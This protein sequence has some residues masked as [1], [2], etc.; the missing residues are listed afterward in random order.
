M[1]AGTTKPTTSPAIYLASSEEILSLDTPKLKD[2]TAID[3]DVL[4]KTSAFINNESRSEPFNEF[5]AMS[6]RRGRIRT[7]ENGTS[8]DLSRDSSRDE[9]TSKGDER[10]SKKGFFG[11]LKNFVSKSQD[12]SD[13]ESEKSQKK[14]KRAKKKKK[15]PTLERPPL[16]E[17]PSH[18][19]RK[20]KL[21]TPTDD[22]PELVY[23][24]YV[25]SSSIE[26]E[27]QSTNFEATT[28][29]VP[30]ETATS[31]SHL[32]QNST[33]SERN[34]R[35]V[36]ASEEV[37]DSLEPIIY[38]R[39]EFTVVVTPKAETVNEPLVTVGDLPPLRP[40]RRKEHVYEDIDQKPD[41]DIKLLT[42]N[43]IYNETHFNP[44][45]D[46]KHIPAVDSTFP[47][48]KKSTPDAQKQRKKHGKL[49]GF[50]TKKSS[51]EVDDSE[52]EVDTDRDI[53]EKQ[54]RESSK[55]RQIKGSFSDEENS[56]QKKTGFF[57]IFVKKS[58]KE[59]EHKE[60]YT[61]TEKKKEKVDVTFK[62]YID[63]TKEPRKNV[64]S[65]EVL[66][67]IKDSDNFLKE[68]ISRFEDVRE[69]TEKQ[70]RESSKERQLKRNFSHEET[71]E[72]KKTGF[73]GIFVKK[74]KKEDD[75][76]E[77]NLATEKKKQKVGAAFKTYIDYTKDSGTKV[78]S[79]EVLEHM[80][81]SDNF[82]KEEISQFEDVRENIEKQ[83]LESSKERQTKGRFSDEE[84]SEQKKSGF[85]GMFMKK[86]KK[87]DD[88]MTEK[89]QKVNT[90]F[91]AYINYDNEEPR[92]MV[93]SNAV[94]KHMKD[95]DNF[96]KEEIAHF[97]DLK[98]RVDPQQ[99]KS[100]KDELQ[101]SKDVKIKEQQPEVV[102]IQQET[103]VEKG[104]YKQK[105]RKDKK[106]LNESEEESD[107]RR[108]GFF[109]LFG[110]KHKKDDAVYVE[111]IPVAEKTVLNV[112][113]VVPNG[114]N[115]SNTFLE[116]EIKYF[117]DVKLV[118]PP[119]QELKIDTHEAIKESDKNSQQI[120]DH[121]VNNLNDIHQINDQPTITL[122]ITIKK[123]QSEILIEKPKDII[124]ESVEDVQNK[125]KGKLNAEKTHDFLNQEILAHEDVK[126]IPVKENIISRTIEAKKSKR[127]DN[128]KNGSIL[129]DEN[130]G[131][132]KSGFFGIFRKK[133]KK[134]GKAIKERS[135][136][137]GKDLQLL[138]QPELNKEIYVSRI[139]INDTD[140]FLKTEIEKFHDVKEFIS[141]H[142]KFTGTPTRDTYE[143]ESVYV[144]K[145]YTK[146]QS[147]DLLKNKAR[148]Y[149]EVIDEMKLINDTNQF[150]S[151]EV[152]HFDDV[153]LVKNQEI[154]IKTLLEE[155]FGE[156]E[157]E[158]IIKLEKSI[159]NEKQ[160][161]EDIL[162]ILSNTNRFLRD[163]ILHFE[164]AKILKSKFEPIAEISKLKDSH[165]RL[166]K[167]NAKKS[168]ELQLDIAIVNE[169]LNTEIK[170][171]EDVKSI[172]IAQP[173]S[174]KSDIRLKV[175]HVPKIEEQK[176]KQDKND[177]GGGVFDIVGKKKHRSSKETKKSSTETEALS[178]QNL[179]KITQPTDQ[180][181]YDEILHFN[182]VILFKDKIVPIISNIKYENIHLENVE[183]KINKH[184]T[185]ESE[186][187]LFNITEIDDFLNTEIK[188]FEDVMVIDIFKPDDVHEVTH[189]S[190][191]FLSDE[192]LNIDVMKSS[193]CKGKPKVK[194][195]ELHIK[196]HH[197][198]DSK[199]GARELQKAMTDTTSTNDFLSTKIKKFE[200]VTKIEIEES[201]IKNQEDT[202]QQEK[203]L[204]IEA[205]KSKDKHDDKSIF[206]F[207]GK[208]RGKSSKD[209]TEMK[210]SE[211]KLSPKKITEITQPT[212]QFL[213][214][215]ILHFDDVKLLKLKTIPCVSEITSQMLQVN[216]VDDNDAKLE[217]KELE[218]ALIDTANS[219]E[220]LVAEVKNFEDVK[221]VNIPK[222]YTEKQEIA[223]KE[224][225]N[226]KAI[227]KI[228]RDEDDYNKR[229]GVFDFFGKKKEKP[230]AVSTKSTI[231][232]QTLLPEDIR[233]IIQGAHKFLAE[234][235]LHFDDVKQLKSSKDE[236][237]VSEL[238][239]QKLEIEPIHGKDNKPEI[240][241]S[242]KT[243]VDIVNSSNFLETEIKKFEDVKQVKIIESQIEKEEIISN[244]HKS[245]K[246]KDKMS[247]DEDN[248]SGGFFDFFGKKKQK[249]TKVSKD[250]TLLTQK[251]SP[252]ELLKITQGTHKFLADEILHFD[253]VKQLKSSKDKP[254]VSELTS[255]KLEIEP[256]HG[257]SDKREIKDSDEALVDKFNSNNFLETEI[258]NFEDVKQAKIV[259]SQIEKQ[260]ITLKGGKSSFTK[261]RMSNDEDSDDK[262][263]GFFDFFVQKKKKSERPSECKQSFCPEEV[264]KIIEETHQFLADEHLHFDDVKPVKSI[265]KPIVSE[266]EHQ[267]L[268]VKQVHSKDEEHKF[269]KSEQA[270]IDTVSSNE[271][272][273]TEIINFED[274]RQVKIAE[275]QI[276]KQEI[277][278]KEQTSSR[279]ENKKPKHQVLKITEGGKQ[280]LNDDVRPQEDKVRDTQ[281]TPLESGRNEDAKKSKEKNRVDIIKTNDF[282][283]NE[284]TYFE[285]VIKIPVG[286]TMIIEQEGDKRSE[287][288]SQISDDESI[289]GKKSGFLGIFSKRDKK[290]IREDER[291]LLLQQKFPEDVL[292]LINDTEKFLNDEILHFND[293]KSLIKN[294]RIQQINL[295]IKESNDGSSDMNENDVSD[296][297][298]AY[299]EDVK[300]DLIDET[301]FEQGELEKKLYRKYKKNRDISSSDD[302]NRSERKISFFGIFG[303]DSKKPPLITEEKKEQETVKTGMKS[304][305]DTKQ[306]L[307]DEV[308]YFDDVMPSSER[309]HHEMKDITKSS[310]E[311]GTHEK[312]TFSET[313]TQVLLN[314][315]S[316]EDF[317]SWEIKNFADVKQV[318]KLNVKEA[319]V[320][321]EDKTKFSTGSETQVENV[322]ER[323][324]K[325]FGLFDKRSKKEEKASKEKSP[326]SGREKIIQRDIQ[327]RDTEKCKDASK[328][329]DI[330]SHCEES[331]LPTSEQVAVEKDHVTKKEKGSLFGMF[332]K[333]AKK[334]EDSK[335]KQSSLKLDDEDEKL[336]MKTSQFLN[337]E[338]THFN[339]VKII[340]IL[341]ISSEEGGTDI[342]LKQ[343]SNFLIK[344][345]MDLTD[346]KAVP[347]ERVAAQNLSEE[348]NLPVE[349]WDGSLEISKESGIKGQTDEHTNNLKTA[350]EFLNNEVRH[351][352]DVRL[353]GGG[354]HVMKFG[355]S[356]KKERVLEEK[357]LRENTTIFL[358][359]EVER[360][361]DVIPTIKTE[362]KEVIVEKTEQDMTYDNLVKVPRLSE[363][364]PLKMADCINF[365]NVEIGK[366]ED[367]KVAFGEKTHLQKEVISDVVGNKKKNNQE[368]LTK[369]KNTLEKDHR[370][371]K[372]G[373]LGLLLKKGKK[374]TTNENGTK[375]TARERETQ[376]E[377]RIVSS[378][379]LIK[380]T[381]SQAI[382]ED[383]KNTSYF[384]A[385]EIQ[386]FDDVRPIIET[387]DLTSVEKLNQEQTAKLQRESSESTNDGDITK[388]TGFFGIFTKKSKKQKP[389]MKDERYSITPEESEKETFVSVDL[390]DRI[391]SQILLREMQETG[392][393]L[394]NEILLF[395]DVKPIIAPP[396]KI[397]GQV[398]FNPNIISTS[399]F[400]MDLSISAPEV[401]PDRPPRRKD[402]VYEDIDEL[403]TVSKEN[404]KEMEDDEIQ[405]V[406]V[407]LVEQEVG[408]TDSKEMVAGKMKL[409][410]SSIQPIYIEKEKS[411]Q[412][413]T[414]ISYAD[415]T[416]GPSENV[417]GYNENIISNMCSTNSF[418]N[419]EIKRSDDV[420][421]IFPIEGYENNSK[422]DESSDIQS[423][424]LVVRELT[425]NFLAYEINNFED[426]K[427]F[428]SKQGD[429]EKVDKKEQVKKTK[430]LDF[431]IVKDSKKG[432]PLIGLFGKKTEESKPTESGQTLE[433]RKGGSPFKLF[434]NKSKEVSAQKSEISEQALQNMYE[435]KNFLST[436]IMRFDDVQMNS[437]TLKGIVDVDKF[438]E[439]IDKKLIF[440][441]SSTKIPTE[442]QQ[443]EQTFR[444]SFQSVE[445]RID[446]KAKKVYSEIQEMIP[447]EGEIEKIDTNKEMDNFLQD[448]KKIKMHLEKE[449]KIEIQQDSMLLSIYDSQKNT[450]LTDYL[451]TERKVEETLSEQSTTPVKVES[452]KKCGKKSGKFFSKIGGKGINKSK[453]GAKKSATVKVKAKGASKPY[454][455]LAKPTESEEELV[456]VAGTTIDYVES[457]ISDVKQTSQ[458]N[459]NDSDENSKKIFEEI[460][461]MG[462]PVVEEVRK[463]GDSIDIGEQG[464]ILLIKGSPKKDHKKSG[465]IFSKIGGKITGKSKDISGTTEKSVHKTE[466]GIKAIADVTIDE[467]IVAKDIIPPKIE[468]EIAQ[469][470]TKD[471]SN[472]SFQTEH[473][474][475]HHVEDVKKEVVVSNEIIIGISDKLSESSDNVKEKIDSGLKDTCDKIQKTLEGISDLS[476]PINLVAENPT[477]FKVSTSKIP[478]CPLE[479]LETKIDHKFDV[480]EYPSSFN[481]ADTEKRLVQK[482]LLVESDNGYQ[483]SKDKSSED[484]KTLTFGSDGTSAGYFSIIGE[485]LGGVS[486]YF[487][488]EVSEVGEKIADSLVGTYTKL[489]EDFVTPS[490]TLFSKRA[491]E[492]NTTEVSKQFDGATS[493]LELNIPEAERETS[494]SLEE[495]SEFSIPFE[496]EFEILQGEVLN[497]ED[498]V[499]NK[500][501]SVVTEVQKFTYHGEDRFSE[502]V[503]KLKA[504]V[505]GLQKPIEIEPEKTQKIIR[506]PLVSL[507][508]Q[509]TDILRDLKEEILN[510]TEDVKLNIGKSKEDVKRTTDVVEPTFQVEFSKQV[511][512]DL[513]KKLEETATYEAGGSEMTTVTENVMP[514][515]GYVISDPNDNEST[516]LKQCIETRETHTTENVD[517]PQN[518]HTAISDMGDW[519]F[520]T[521]YKDIDTDDFIKTEAKDESDNES[522]VGFFG[523]IGAK[524]FG[525]ARKDDTKTTTITDTFIK[526]LNWVEQECPETV[527][528]TTTQKSSKEPSMEAVK[529]RSPFVTSPTLPRRA[530][531]QR[532]N[533]DDV[534]YFVDVSNLQHDDSSSDESYV[535]TEPHDFVNVS[536]GDSQDKVDRKPL[537][538]IESFESFDTV[539]SQRGSIKSNIL[540]QLTKKN[541]EVLVTD[542]DDEIPKSTKFT[543]NAIFDSHHSKD[544]L[545]SSA[546]NETEILEKKLDDIEKT[547]DSLEER[548]LEAKY[549]TKNERKLKRVERKFERMSSEGLRQDAT[550]AKQT[551]P[552]TPEAEERRENEFQQLVSLPSTEGASDFHKEYLTL[553]D[554]QTFTHNDDMDSS[555]TS[556]NHSEEVLELPQGRSY[557]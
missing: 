304:I 138:D 230:I 490:D 235:I 202:L 258:K 168:E 198:E 497:M 286:D 147:K 340:H 323:K 417:S 170:H 479:S 164:D 143:K 158:E 87:E 23:I 327:T 200:H 77:D 450:D 313:D 75:H 108:G 453:D 365:L 30:G 88:Q 119:Q 124:P 484:A 331:M 81:D 439:H 360:F 26:N 175:Q 499:T 210:I 172:Q 458:L 68:E 412:E 128:T 129:E 381:L 162:I 160:P 17:V 368:K 71:S 525:K 55:E 144:D 511:Q 151:D 234:E 462:K 404:I 228:P 395:H 344:E 533:R 268:Q 49:F 399:E 207:F 243:L 287:T 167:H 461:E 422:Y 415:P 205:K 429:K 541:I 59:D 73:F 166:E 500:T 102:N 28:K 69:N 21:P 41:L 31:I 13:S 413:E 22:R 459:L 82:L 239:P 457:K 492:L 278:I 538:H 443:N 528:S 388:K 542:L 477:G 403:M 63:D 195:D 309:I 47:E 242:D 521:R 364:A 177:N 296:T 400:P 225:E 472:V 520:V 294:D 171:F 383:L 355:T 372:S 236:P 512:D 84:S 334:H 336:R 303:K 469:K 1:I 534:P 338:V 406:T 163:E 111:K 72:Q 343:A 20:P 64:V 95:S 145:C 473:D 504:E 255:E 262:N 330:I 463:Q 545:L 379:D 249:S 229:G 183:T 460:K 301:K 293:V 535:V 209:S 411:K 333:K 3:K 79:D 532:I 45:V 224:K 396:R 232:K 539:P 307:G 295:E 515:S 189:E 320:P 444:D 165:T 8:K 19:P 89:K 427:P 117:D 353:V 448:T 178:Q 357:Q 324:N 12:H 257:K 222:P 553:L 214:D 14:D 221:Q 389:V 292:I 517:L 265:I 464:S 362:I 37:N 6:V 329:I 419:K 154:L 299:H 438:H 546:K 378:K 434:P 341:D 196:Q 10:S 310:D 358:Q 526:D 552:T 435:T 76:K 505:S 114:T 371:K 85:L 181:L 513:D 302:Q 350:I 159:N 297:E 424:Y 318:S 518:I 240:K 281:K 92:T 24:P 476:T 385:G 437:L 52:E 99:E 44:W 184:D 282:L 261:H 361:E 300:A 442:L 391:D 259:E 218:K 112:I 179:L 93:L 326:K 204:K 180:F 135:P 274:V 94:L 315:I 557:I 551:M 241:D 122:D 103:E 494:K 376:S 38:G 60:D 475:K 426:V 267:E 363:D 345:I 339:D 36:T 157:K 233:K 15:R 359:D 485:K 306:F 104:K 133:S 356:E 493:N 253:D 132:K 316:I 449:M 496:R 416:F 291:V 188:N 398:T 54:D 501:E 29:P 531:S 387:T 455:E 96:L 433:R 176:P 254:T 346:V 116:E 109:G 410:S 465:G 447:A 50:L 140:T 342:S 217:T 373:I 266:I 273:N 34:K 139:T 289:R 86:T 173:R 436:E 369:D 91:K 555:K 83:N 498:N 502:N 80:K 16:T 260:E 536:A 321:Q 322:T 480:M 4:E 554:E 402:Q 468:N 440:V 283:K 312:C 325:F 298:I 432:K 146:L 516:K 203:S 428:I 394:F 130:D 386:H 390:R 279:T 466:K 269:K 547:L 150:L 39:G 478:E 252:K 487:K 185:K 208:K 537:F 187:A 65:D 216:P 393:F 251:L 495:I 284:V 169:F 250:S 192:I 508:G 98:L 127:C 110:K 548:N 113:G 349:Q 245:L 105:I 215:E 48:I 27:N 408:V 308:V 270:L 100:L 540:D 256:I 263:G 524:I 288:E 374:D 452:P 384:L 405:K 121:E 377:K 367:V 51:K 97:E 46:D 530:L 529:V 70:D 272:L 149:K 53:I 335:E 67:Y 370:E 264:L 194:Y 277:I 550:E 148:K 347:I 118:K 317:L 421:L 220:F 314:K 290:S 470:I 227:G 244:E 212:H 58:R 420:G 328:Q 57:G 522:R 543:D 519:T 219:N 247:K 206:D 142:E 74:S 125:V 423:K 409:M 431:Q 191:Q 62:T 107:A 509:C 123:K 425:D 9:D 285:D 454:T 193:Q 549:E 201:Q 156:F 197:D 66:G 33:F 152:L 136:T 134:G 507:D 351:Y 226:S 471:L 401:P 337:D 456:K 319:E 42:T 32:I 126:L 523:N 182:D 101:Q 380:P 488:D 348:I 397:K 489:E 18:P 556:E 375:E 61:L 332:T 190:Q 115:S 366:Y 407:K 510:T 467:M 382:C 446:P 7:V 527:K 276:K 90:T 199:S 275:P 418:L 474:V 445:N 25:E 223:L 503:K 186:R 354:K 246:A 481:V 2:L 237:A 483:I 161:S 11:T 56:E 305:N 280:F 430:T 311:P 35:T 231:L 174:S 106:P 271:F 40:Q 131:E 5:T 153:K 414:S 211:D 78:L 43:L 514:K 352:E 155:S 491:N 137:P 486:R 544:D 120:L 392:Q 238:T 506:D 248:K 451:A 141:K 482:F 441:D 213:T